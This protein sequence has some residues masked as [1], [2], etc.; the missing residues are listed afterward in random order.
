MSGP[1]STGNITCPKCGSLDWNAI[2]VVHSSTPCRLALTATGI[3]VAF[4]SRAEMSREASTSVVTHYF[5]AN[6]GCGFIVYPQGL[7]DLVNA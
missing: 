7:A 5:C 1:D 6:E 4:D 3:E 2:E